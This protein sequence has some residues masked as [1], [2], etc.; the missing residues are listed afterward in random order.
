MGG[1][2]C[3]GHLFHGKDV[4][5]LAETH[6]IDF[7]EA[8]LAQDFEDTELVFGECKIPGLSMGS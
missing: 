6:L 3:F 5:I 4:I 1:V 2:H 8:S 7:S